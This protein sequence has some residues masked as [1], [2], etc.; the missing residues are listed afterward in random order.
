MNPD[1]AGGR[2]VTP[3][4]VR[5]LVPEMLRYYTSA[6]AVQRSMSLLDFSDEALQ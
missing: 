6:P 2:I 1:V 5:T 4:Q 3:F